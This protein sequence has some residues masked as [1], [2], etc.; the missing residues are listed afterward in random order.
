MTVG[1]VRYD[2]QEATLRRL[3]DLCGGLRNLTGCKVLLKPNV[4]IG[5]R[6]SQPPHGL[7]TTTRVVEQMINLVRDLGSKEVIIAEG[8]AVQEDLSLNTPRAYKWSGIADLAERMQIPLVDLNDGPFVTYTYEGV[9]IEIARPILEA[10]YVIN[11]PVLKTHQLTKISLGIKNLK[12]VLSPKSK[13]DFHRHGLEKFIG[14]LPTKVRVDFTVIDGTYAL[15]K[16]PVGN[17]VHSMNVLVA[18]KDLLALD[19]VGASLL[20]INPNDVEHLQVYAGLTGRTLDLASVQVKGERI[21]ELRKPLEWQ[22]KWPQ[23]LLDLY[24]IS[25]VHME[26]PGNSNCSGCGMG[27]FVAL[28]RFFRENAGA[29][30]DGVEICAGREPVASPQAKKVF[31][32][33]KCAC[34]TNA[35]H[36]NAIKIRGCPPSVERIYLRL[37]EELVERN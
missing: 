7:V 12:G 11:L 28:N 29:T 36:P 31:C 35:D 19:A 2:G 6:R 25:G 22:S 21:E 17:D 4:V 18:G 5:G 14:W 13:K 27:I 24:K 34:E 1:L 33:G 8:G 32:L 23:E 30:F 15:Q 16:G 10:D 3:V 37:K 26:T 9:K 20:G